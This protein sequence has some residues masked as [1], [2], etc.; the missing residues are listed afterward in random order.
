MIKNDVFCDSLSAKLKN[1]PALSFVLF[2][3]AKLSQWLS[4]AI[5]FLLGTDLTLALFLAR[6]GS[7]ESFLTK[8]FRFCFSSKSEPL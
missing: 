4:Y 6:Y 2:Q 3:M 7:C 1:V 5:L 8:S